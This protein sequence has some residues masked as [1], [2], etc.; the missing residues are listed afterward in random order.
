M[1]NDVADAA[2]VFLS[3]GV[4]IIK[5]LLQNCRRE[6]DVVGCCAVAGI[7]RKRLHEPV[8]LVN[9]RV[10]LGK[11]F[12]FCRRL[13][14]DDVREERAALRRALDVGIIEIGLPAVGV[15]D[16]DLHRVEFAD[17]LLLCRVRHPVERF[18]ARLVDLEEFVN[19]FLDVL[20]CLFREVRFNIRA[21]QIIS[22]QSLHLLGSNLLGGL[23]HIDA[24]ICLCELDA[25]LDEALIQAPADAHQNCR[26]GKCLQRCKTGIVKIARCRP[27]CAR[28]RHQN[29]VAGGKTGRL[30][31]LG[32][33]DFRELPLDVAELVDVVDFIYIPVFLRVIGCFGNLCLRRIDELCP[34]RRRLL[35][36]TRKRQQF[37]EIGK[38]SVLLLLCSVFIEILR[39]RCAEGRERDDLAV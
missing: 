22:Q 30:V 12:F 21:S 27:H 36:K 2:E 39:H 25:C 23:G 11:C 26:P 37:C 4:H 28:V 35:G 32:K 33:A 29:P 18:D 13:N 31:D 14:G 19:H 17:C 6:G 1:G 8:G 34:L 20:L 24:V 9:R 16:L 7:D 3:R 15:A 10:L 5:R 38:I